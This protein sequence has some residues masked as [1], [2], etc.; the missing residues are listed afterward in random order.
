MVTCTFR[1]SRWSG[2]PAGVL[3]LW[4]TM[5]RGGSHEPDGWSPFK[6]PDGRELRILK[7]TGSSNEYYRVVEQHPGKFY[8]KMTITKANGEKARRG[9]RSSAKGRPRPE[10]RA[11]C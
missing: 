5:P 11:S 9:R 8:P 1:R 10:R 3:P 7:S 2:Q 6:A 4:I